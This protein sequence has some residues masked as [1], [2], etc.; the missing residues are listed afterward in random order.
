MKRY[1]ALAQDLARSIQSGLLQPGERLPSVRETCAARK[2]SP[3]TVFRAYHLLET[4]GLVESR[5]RS[6]FYV[7]RGRIRL[8]PEPEMASRPDGESRAVDVS[9]LVFQ[10]LRSSM[11]RDRVPLG[12]AFPSPMLFPLERLGRS[13]AKAAIHLDPWSTVDDLT[14]GQLALRRQIARRY[15]LDGIDIEAEDIVITNGAMEAMSL[16]ITAVTRPGDAVLVES[17]CFYITLQILE[18]N[19]LRAIE[20]PTHPREGVDL[21]ALAQAIA[22][23]APR[24]CWLMPTF[25]NPLGSTMPE[26]NKRALATLLAEHGV[27]LVEDDVYSELHFQPTR[28]PPVKAYDREGLVLHCGSFSKCLAPGYRIGWVVPGRFRTQVARA[29]LT[30]TLNTN[31]PGQ[32]AIAGYLEGGGYERHLR[33]LRERLAHQQAQY[34]AAIA[35]AFPRETRVTR[36]M[37]GYFLWL[38]LPAGTDALTLRQRALAHGMSLAPG[39]MF[40][41]SRGFGNCL[42]LN[43]G[44]PFD[45]RMAD[46]VA[47]LGRLAAGMA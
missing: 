26:A 1:E 15:R 24:A 11:N 40:S 39:P 14:P 16:S 9:D 38:E 45:A 8:P 46:A 28:P 13:M 18:R 5:P 36:P 44:H 21:E 47:T 3:S 17:P 35:E 20:V 6:G 22:R 37:G 2:I 29:K 42:R 12:S 43:C 31:V 41:P 32:L 33:Q 19:G 30:S 34:V 4:R 23:H 7:A 25:H 10:V 27:P